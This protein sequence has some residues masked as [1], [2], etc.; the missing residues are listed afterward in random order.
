M[1]KNKK[2][3]AHEIILYKLDELKK[4]MDDEIK[5]KLD[6]IQKDAMV[7]N[8]ATERNT[9]NIKWLMW[10]IRAAI[11]GIIA[12]SGFIYKNYSMSKCLAQEEIKIER[13]KK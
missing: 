3:S 2:K 6:I 4:C 8:I 11:I 9:T 13:S 5:P 12:S 10:A 7:V 1:K